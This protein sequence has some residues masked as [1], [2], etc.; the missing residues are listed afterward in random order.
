VRLPKLERTG[1]PWGRV[2]SA[3]VAGAQRAPAWRGSTFH[4]AGTVACPS[5]S[6][7]AADADRP[8]LGLRAYGVPVELVAC[9]SV[10]E[11]APA[12]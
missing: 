9:A 11:L 12:C 1:S 4:S 8:A 6:G 2:V 10:R 3:S 7:P 5:F